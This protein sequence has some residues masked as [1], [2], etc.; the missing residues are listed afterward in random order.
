MDWQK[1]GLTMKKPLTIGFEFE[2][3][4]GEK[5]FWQFLA[6]QLI[7]QAVGNY[8]DKN[9]IKMG[10]PEWDDI[11]ANASHLFHISYTQREKLI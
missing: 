9:N 11:L 7:D 3:I 5:H 6:S 4:E 1:Q 10:S 8:S 2:T